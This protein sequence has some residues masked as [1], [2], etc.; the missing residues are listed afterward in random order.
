[1]SSDRVT[2]APDAAGVLGNR[3][4]K[5]FSEIYSKVRDLTTSG[6]TPIIAHGQ[7]HKGASLDTVET[8]GFL[9]RLYRSTREKCAFLG[10][11]QIVLNRKSGKDSIGRY[12]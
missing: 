10:F 7:G 9:L 5:W 2:I 4:R 3:A 8:K 12:K 1:M 6:G 11:Y